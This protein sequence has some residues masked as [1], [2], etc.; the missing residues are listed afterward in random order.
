MIQS[1]PQA[2]PCQEKRTPKIGAATAT[3]TISA[4]IVKARERPEIAGRPSW[5][6]DAVELVQT[7]QKHGFRIAGVHETVVGAGDL[8]S[9]STFES[10]I[11]KDEP[12]V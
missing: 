3:K 9:A 12:T 2:G 10:S 7:A 4:A 8:I 1:T 6:G 11:F 5:S